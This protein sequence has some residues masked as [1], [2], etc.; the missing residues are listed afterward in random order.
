MKS[1]ITIL[2]ISF[3]AS[4]IEANW[5]SNKAKKGKK[6]LHSLSLFF[7]VVLGLIICFVTSCLT[8][9]FTIDILVGTGLYMFVSGVQYWITFDL[10]FNLFSGNK[11]YYIGSTS[12][13]DKSTNKSPKETLTI[14]FVS[15]FLF[16]LFNYIFIIA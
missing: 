5:D 8:F 3:I 11:W 6:I 14:K 16:V 13:I 12:T 10:F 1:L 4:L 9:E 15:Y 7:R 2:I